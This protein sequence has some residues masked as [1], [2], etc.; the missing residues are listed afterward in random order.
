MADFAITVGNSVA[1]LGMGA[2]TLWGFFDWG[3]GFWG[4]G[5]NPMVFAVDKA[6]DAETLTLADSISKN[7]GR[8]VWAE[9]IVTAC[10][11]TDERL[12]DA[13]GYYYV[14][15]KP[16]LDADE[17]NVTSYTEDTPSVTSWASGTV[18]GPTWSEQ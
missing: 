12:Q 5:S 6:L 8:G 2:P 1:V 10:E 11:A 14:F 18:T 9:S 17:R 15:T 13:N 7:T 4:A 3:T 16:T